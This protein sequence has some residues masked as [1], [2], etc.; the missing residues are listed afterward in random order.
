MGVR[1]D[2]LRLVTMQ[3]LSPCLV[4]YATPVSLQTENMDIAML[5]C[6][7]ESITGVAHDET[8]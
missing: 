6:Q 1:T 5:S 7:R 4:L 8:T 3:M 2:A